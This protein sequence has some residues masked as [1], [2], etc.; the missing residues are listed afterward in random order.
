MHPVHPQACTLPD[1]RLPAALQSHACLSSHSSDGV[2]SCLL[3]GGLSCKLFRGTRRPKAARAEELCSKLR[4]S[5]VTKPPAFVWRLMCWPCA[6][7]MSRRDVLEYCTLPIQVHEASAG[8][9]GKA[10]LVQTSWTHT[11]TFSRFLVGCRISHV[12]KHVGSVRRQTPFS[13]DVLLGLFA[14]IW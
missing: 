4:C 9:L 5:C 14:G 7:I 12:C 2:F 13:K 6:P 3:V 1:K 8:T 10:Q 11:T